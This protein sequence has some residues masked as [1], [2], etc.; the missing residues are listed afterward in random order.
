MISRGELIG[1][2]ILIVIGAT[3]I[4]LAPAKH[5]CGARLTPRFY[6]FINPLTGSRR[7]L[8]VAR[9]LVR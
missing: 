3:L 7:T 8:E 9:Q 6:R 2:A 1:V 4:A 5:P